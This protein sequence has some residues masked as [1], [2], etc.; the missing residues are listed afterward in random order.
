M[1]FGS[2]TYTCKHLLQ[3]LVIYIHAPR[4]FDLYTSNCREAT[5]RCK[6]HHTKPLHQDD[7]TL[8]RVSEVLKT[9]PIAPNFS[10]LKQKKR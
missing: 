1:S 7:D 4:T 2:P 10:E 9:T 6:K 8:P 5:I 3:H